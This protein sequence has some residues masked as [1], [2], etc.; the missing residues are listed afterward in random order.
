MKVSFIFLGL[1]VE[2]KIVDEVLEVDCGEVAVDEGH[3]DPVGVA[4][5]LHDEPSHPILCEVVRFIHH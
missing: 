2:G 1:R 4:G 3:D 5:V